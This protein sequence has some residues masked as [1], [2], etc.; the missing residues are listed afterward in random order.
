MEAVVGLV[1]GMVEP[2]GFIVLETAASLCVQ[3]VKLILSLKSVFM[4]TIGRL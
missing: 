1:V 4:A 2:G 3:L